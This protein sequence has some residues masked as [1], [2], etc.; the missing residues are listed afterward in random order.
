M[1]TLDAVRAVAISGATVDGVADSVVVAGSTQ[2]E[3]GGR[4][5][6][7][8]PP[9]HKN[10]TPNNSLRALSPNMYEQCASPRQF[11]L[12]ACFCCVWL[13]TRH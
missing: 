9:L 12:F 4:D 3:C 6:F 1:G 10:H 5:I 13:P 8:P 2:G 11:Q 7:L